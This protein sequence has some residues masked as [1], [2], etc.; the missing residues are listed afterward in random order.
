KLIVAKPIVLD[1]L[2]LKNCRQTEVEQLTGSAPGESLG[3]QF[4][5][6]D[7]EILV[8][9]SHQQPIVHVNQGTRIELRANE[10]TGLVHADFSAVEGET[11]VLEA[12]VAGQWL[13]D[14]V[15]SLPA[16]LVADWSQHPPR[17]R[18]GKL[19][20]RLRSPLTRQQNVHLVIN[21]RRRRA[22][23]NDIFHASDLALLKFN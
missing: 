23:S 4:F 6:E 5:E 2:Q 12:D 21:A 16:G 11:F 7:P 22:P 9:A 19:T 15:V 13:I 10:G 1:E 18:S 3:I 17:G 14:N 20:V 8:S